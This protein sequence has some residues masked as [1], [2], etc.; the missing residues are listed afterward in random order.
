MSYE[1][2]VIDHF[3]AAHQINE[4]HDKCERLHGHNWQVIVWVIA[5]ELDEH[6]LVVDFR[7]LK[8][9]LKRCLDI[10]DHNYINDLPAFKDINATS[11]NIAYFIYKLFYDRDI[12]KKI[13]KKVECK[14]C[15]RGDKRI[16]SSRLGFW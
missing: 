3:S 13:F 1:V 4:T 8:N 14:S 5:K 10:L 2:S 16:V 11:E 7:I 12:Y 6:G 15:S 9:E